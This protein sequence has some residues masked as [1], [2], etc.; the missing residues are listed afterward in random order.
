MQTGEVHD[1]LLSASPMCRLLTLGLVLGA[2]TLAFAAS[3]ATAAI[4]RAEPA[5]AL[6]LPTWAIHVSSVTEWIVAMNLFWRYAEVTGAFLGWQDCIHSTKE[7]E[8]VCYVFSDLQDQVLA[9]DCSLSQVKP[10]GSSWSHFHRILNSLMGQS[11]SLS[12]HW[13]ADLRSDAPSGLFPSTYTSIPLDVGLL[14]Y[15]VLFRKIG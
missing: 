5:N 2:A 8:D 6:S 12:G 14:V 9:S 4:F 13:P 1:W 7:I 15:P 3:P 11:C 10:I